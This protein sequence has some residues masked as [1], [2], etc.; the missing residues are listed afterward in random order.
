MYAQM[1][2]SGK[3]GICFQSLSLSFF[4]QLS[5]EAINIVQIDILS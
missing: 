4:G 5:G 3:Y 2:S 1:M